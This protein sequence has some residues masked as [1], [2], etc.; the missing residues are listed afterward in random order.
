MIEVKG[1]PLILNLL[2]YGNY[3]KV[4]IGETAFAIGHPDGLVWTFTN[5]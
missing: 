1:C 5:G 2:T 4:K 3:K